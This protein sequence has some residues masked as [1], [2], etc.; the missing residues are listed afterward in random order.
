MFL[1]GL[2]L[3]VFV[4]VAVGRRLGLVLVA[5]VLTLTESQLSYRVS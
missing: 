3:M 2:A 4:S 5:I 1:K